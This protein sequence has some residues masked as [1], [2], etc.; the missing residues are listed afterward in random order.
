MHKKLLFCLSFLSIT[1]SFAQPLAGTYTIG[2]ADPDYA[3]IA[4]AI[5]DLEE[6]GL[7]G[8]VVFN[9]RNGTHTAQSFTLTQVPGQAPTNTITFQSESG[10]AADVVIADTFFKFSLGTQNIFIKNLHF[11]GGTRKIQVDGSSQVINVNV[12]D[13][14]FT[15]TLPL[16][17]S[18]M[19]D[20][21]FL[22]NVT[23]VM[24][25]N[26]MDIIIDGNVF[27]NAGY[28]IN[29]SGPLTDNLTFSN[30]I[31][32]GGA[33]PIS[34]QQGRNVTITG[35]TY[36]GAI[37]MTLINLTNMDDN[38]LIA[39]N[40]FATNSTWL[41][42]GS[43]TI[44]GN[45]TAGT[46]LTLQN[47]FFDMPYPLTVQAFINTNI[48]YNSF[49]SAQGYC[50][51]ITESSNLVAYNIYN[52]IF[53]NGLDHFTIDAQMPAGL[54]KL[55]M[56]HNAYSN[57]NMICYRHFATETESVTYDFADWKAFSGEDLNSK[58]VNNV[59]GTGS[60]L[61][62]PNMIMLDGAGMQVAGITTDIDGEMRNA[63]APDIGADEFTMDLSTFRDLAIS[64]TSPVSACDQSTISV[65]VQN[66]SSFPVSGFE[67][68]CAINNNRGNVTPYLDTLGPGETAV[69]DLSGCA[70]TPNSWYEK[71]EVFVSN[72][73]G[74]I[75]NNYAND[76]A[77]F[78]DL[79]QFGEFEIKVSSGDCDADRVIYIPQLYGA[80][81]LWSTGATTSTITANDPGTYSV[82]ITDIGGCTINKSITLE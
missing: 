12:T 1:F 31:I 59:F 39:N 81:Q 64:I 38:L 32:N 76:R 58:I 10:N 52:N 48:Y 7:A 80:T 9:F 44:A 24:I 19:S 28:A 27:N 54:T 45:Y 35:N 13:C 57:E 62:V 49:R 5:A 11:S 66:L 73:A 2:G 40:R 15:N 21:T 53:D 6:F 4:L 22:G 37:M 74:Q 82:T 78:E 42:S 75:D 68:E 72:P 60:D 61:H 34:M 43:G 65:A 3:T 46:N 70:I 17:L 30:N 8:S 50:L 56:D 71:Y 51:D 63:T 55:N 47:N 41:E 14:I 69:F 25:Y 16:T 77:L 67:L 36:N 20:S 18:A 29:K 23:Q 79:F 33:R 26:G